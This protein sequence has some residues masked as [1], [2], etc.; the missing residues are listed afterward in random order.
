MATSKV[1]V[2]RKWH[3]KVPTD[4]A[5]KPLPKS[6]WPRKRPHRW[7]VRWFGSEGTRY[8][9]SFDGRKE[10]E[11]FAESKQSE[12]R[13]GA[14][15]E[16]APITLME[17]KRMYLSLRGDI[18]AGT[19]A[20]HS[21]TLKLLIEHLGGERLIG[22]ITPLE[23][24]EFVSWYRQKKHLGRA[25]AAATVNKLVRECHRIFREAVDCSL[26]R[27]NPFN[28]IR[29]D[30][31]GQIAWQYVS[32]AHFRALIAACPSL[33]WRGMITLA[34]CCGLR[35][36]EILHLTWADVDFERQL[37][38]V[39]R[40]PASGV[41]EA[42][43]P[44]DKD[45]RLVPLPDEAANVL[46]ELQVAAVEGQTY[47]VVNGKGPD[48]GERVKR[49]NITR[50]FQA[51]RRRAGVPRCKFHD[52]RKSYCT[53]I[54]QRTPLHVVQQL[55]GH[56]DIRTTQKHYLQVQ[57]EMVDAARRAVEEMLKCTA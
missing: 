17:Y 20:E 23:A 13:D 33:K 32:P 55:A 49:Q 54:A 12:V 43:C 19:R 52:L 35:L 48:V 28:G 38:R 8:S 10:A 26:I 24:R 53:N 57:P 40:K 16:P 51:I 56:S 39:V 25:P 37:V 27:A 47:V 2:F 41:T 31:V 11:R 4:S 44:K 15:E 18:T 36:G 9:R 7:A 1:G 42:W 22:K 5:G 45:M 46:S 6:E 14:G 34:Y 21:R 30:K 29:Q 3:G 50:D